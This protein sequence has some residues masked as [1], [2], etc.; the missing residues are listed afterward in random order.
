MGVQKE[1]S[2]EVNSVCF[3]ANMN[4]AALTSS[5]KIKFNN[6]LEDMVTNFYILPPDMGLG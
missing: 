5:L 2:R 1:S 6:R 3:K 4:T